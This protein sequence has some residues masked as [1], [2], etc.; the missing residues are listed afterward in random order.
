MTV[1]ETSI[2]SCVSSGTSSWLPIWPAWPLYLCICICSRKGSQFSALLEATF[3][4]STNMCQVIWGLWVGCGPVVLS[5]EM[6]CHNQR[7]DSEG[8]KDNKKTCFQQEGLRHVHS[9]ISTGGKMMYICWHKQREI[10]SSV[11]ASMQKIRFLKWRRDGI[12]YE[13]RELTSISRG[14]GKKGEEG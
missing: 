3:E 14:Q 6:L 2:N 13:W 10:Q 1:Y 12:A 5:S 7:S 8:E 9:D 4:I 11:L